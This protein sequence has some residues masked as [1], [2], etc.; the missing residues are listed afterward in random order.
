M[1][2]FTIDEL[3]KSDTAARR[4]IDNTPTPVAEPPD[5]RMWLPLALVVG[6]GAVGIWLSR[7]K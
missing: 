7:R 6:A 3:C 1:R 4:G 2:F 5:W